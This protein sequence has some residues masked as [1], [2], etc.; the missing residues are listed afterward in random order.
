MKLSTRLL[1]RVEMARLL[2]AGQPF[3]KSGL[4]GSYAT[5][6]FGVGYGLR[7]S[8]FA[9]TGLVVPMAVWS[10]AICRG[11]GTQLLPDCAPDSRCPSS[12]S[13]THLRAHETPEHLV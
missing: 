6:M 8:R 10:A 12:V 5:E 9:M 4:D 1:N 13:Y 2:P 3:S 11:S 7:A